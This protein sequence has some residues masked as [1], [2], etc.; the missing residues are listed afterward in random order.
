MQL[1]IGEITG[2]Y[3]YI[4]PKAEDIADVGVGTRPFY[5]K[6]PIESK[7][8]LE[9]FYN[10]VAKNKDM[11][12]QLQN[13]SPLEIKGGIIDLSKP[14]PPVYG[15]T[16]LIGDS[17][18]QNFAYVGEGIIPGWQAAIIAG[19]KVSESLENGSTKSLNEYPKEYEN[20]FIGREAKKTV[21]IKDNISNV[22]VM[23]IDNKLK[24][25]LISML[26]LE[27]INWDGKELKQALSIK[28]PQILLKY[29]EKLIDQKELKIDI[30]LK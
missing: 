11:K 23:D 15:N 14:L 26:E 18:N 30:N 17:A 21:K 7:S 2:G 9:L 24:T 28:N 16:I 1:F 6:N 12:R 22:T 8:P 27:I 5:G 19:E 13:A 25:I 10:L 20:S 29:A 3:G 4:F